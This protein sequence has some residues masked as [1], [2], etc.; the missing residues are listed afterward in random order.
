MS[1]SANEDIDE[2]DQYLQAPCQAM[3]I[4]PLDFWKEETRNYPTIAKVAESICNILVPLESFIIWHISTRS[5][6]Y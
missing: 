1:T 6:L 2:L 4:N 3:T 5:F